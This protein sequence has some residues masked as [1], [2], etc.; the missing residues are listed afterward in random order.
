MAHGLLQSALLTQGWLGPVHPRP[1]RVWCRRVLV[2]TVLPLLGCLAYQLLQPQ[3]RRNS[4]ARNIRSQLRPVVSGRSFQGWRHLG[5]SAS[6]CR[7][8]ISGGWRYTRVSRQVFCLYGL[9]EEAWRSTSKNSLPWTNT[10]C[11]FTSVT[12]PSSMSM[13]PSFVPLVASSLTAQPTRS[14]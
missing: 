3:G 9:S 5:C 6:G 8:A 13:I 10:S 1:R 4:P 2:G 12:V 7:S 11:P 14:P